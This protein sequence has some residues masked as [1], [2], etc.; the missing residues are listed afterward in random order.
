MLWQG[1]HLAIIVLQWHNFDGAHTVA[2]V[3]QGLEDF[4]EG[5]LSKRFE[6]REERSVHRLLVHWSRLEIPEPTTAILLLA[7]TISVIARRR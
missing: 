2:L 4:A 5:A 1:T 3:V 6:Q 7:G